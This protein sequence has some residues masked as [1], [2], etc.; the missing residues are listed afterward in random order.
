MAP[1][2]RAGAGTAP[3]S[4][5]IVRRA[6]SRARPTTWRSSNPKDS[7]NEANPLLNLVVVTAA[8]GGGDL[9]GDDAGLALD[10]AHHGPRR[11]V[12]HGLE[13]VELAAAVPQL[14]QA[15]AAAVD[16]DVHDVGAAP[17]G[18][19]APARGLEDAD[20]A[21]ATA[22]S[23]AS[24]FFEPSVSSTELSH[25]FSDSALHGITSQQSGGSGR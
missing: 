25:I 17:V 2:S 18:E 9:G 3:E 19:G 11:R 13:D 10:G 15:R 4:R 1:C 8:A 21:V 12:I 16:G 23:T 20:P 5:R 24:G 22:S 14:Q 6:R 7:D